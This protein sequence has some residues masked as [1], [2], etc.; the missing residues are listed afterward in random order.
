MPNVKAFLQKSA[1]EHLIKIENSG[2]LY[3]VYFFLSMLIWN[4]VWIKDKVCPWWFQGNICRNLVHLQN[5]SKLTVLKVFFLIFPIEIR[6]RKESKCVNATHWIPSKQWGA[7]WLSALRRAGATYWDVWNELG[8]PPSFWTVT[9]VWASDE[10]E[11]DRQRAAR[12]DLFFTPTFEPAGF[13]SE[14]QWIVL[15]FT[16]HWTF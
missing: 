16:L 4:I 1:C 11:T 12:G 3:S 6:N 13:M 5:N 10:R 14:I 2:A 7:L 9:F 8:L 15:A